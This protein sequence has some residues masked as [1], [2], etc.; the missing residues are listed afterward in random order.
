MENAFLW[1]IAC[2]LFNEIK[3]NYEI[4][5]E[6]FNSLKG[7]YFLFQGFFLISIRFLLL[8][9]AGRSLCNF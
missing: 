1:Q 8:L 3:K 6:N 9:R 5:F 7:L 4:D 2:K